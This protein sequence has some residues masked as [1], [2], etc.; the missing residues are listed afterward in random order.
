MPSP[1]GLASCVVASAGDQILDCSGV[2]ARAGRP[3]G[4]LGGASD[5]SAR[6]VSTHVLPHH[7]V[8]PRVE[9]A[10]CGT[11]VTGRKARDGPAST[12]STRES[13]GRTPRPGKFRSDN[14]RLSSVPLCPF[15]L[16]PNTLCSKGTSCVRPGAASHVPLHVPRTAPS[17]LAAP[18]YIDK[19][20]W[21][22]YI[23]VK[24]ALLVSPLAFPRR[25]LSLRCGPL[26]PVVPPRHSDCAR[27]RRPHPAPPTS[28]PLPR[29]PWVASRDA[30]GP[31]GERAGP[32]ERSS[33]RPKTLRRH[34][35]RPAQHARGAA[36]RSIRGLVDESRNSQC[37]ARAAA[38]FEVPEVRSRVRSGPPRCCPRRKLAQG[39]LDFPYERAVVSAW[40]VPG[41]S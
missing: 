10:P 19:N 18:S 32:V 8:L 7:S 30:V 13:R 20:V 3:G 38:L 27:I 16:A 1:V 23:Q 41:A 11:V 21:R 35:D 14:P 24:R 2:P 33:G 40:G 29:R 4:R 15:C 31:G 28:P 26:K 22:A 9:C 12:K 25:A 34:G 36:L 6:G 39:R 37:S 5:R 17:G